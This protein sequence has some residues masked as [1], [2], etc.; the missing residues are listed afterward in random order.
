M[1][2]L[3][4][5]KNKETKEKWGRD[6]EFIKRVNE[7][8]NEK[9]LLARVWDVTHVAPP[10]VTTTDELDRIVTIIDES[11][12]QAEQEFASEVNA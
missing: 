12:G 4:I 2:G 10:L 1:C 11:L 5:V 8:M 9:G 6:A 3:E 7:L